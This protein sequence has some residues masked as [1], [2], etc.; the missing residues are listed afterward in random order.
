MGGRFWTYFRGTL[1]WPLIWRPGPLACIA[2]GLARVMDDVLADILWL[3][4]Q[5]SPATC[6][7]RFIPHFARARGIRRHSLEGDAR[8]AARVRKAYAW[9]LL[10]G[11]TEGMPKI[12][13]HYGYPGS[14]IV[15]KRASDPAR[16][17]E[18]D[19]AVPPPD[20]GLAEGDYALL[21][22]AANDTK[23]ASAKLAGIR[24]ESERRA[25]LP[26]A[27]CAEQSAEIVTVYP[28]TVGSV[29]TTPALR[30]A[31]GCQTVETVTIQPQ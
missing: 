30:T 6:E 31:I 15:N 9:Q 11:L 1:A 29:E 8:F 13:E 23:A 3:R 21:E 17:A 5:F 2:E 27:A 12:F 14:R 22:W 10:G 4:D 19:V 7:D 16:W 28:W 24:I 18:F 20:T 25:K 26:M